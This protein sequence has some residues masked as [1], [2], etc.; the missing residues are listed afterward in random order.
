MLRGLHSEFTIINNKETKSYLILLGS[1]SLSFSLDTE[2]T[3]FESQ[4]SRSQFDF[5]PSDRFY[6]HDSLSQGVHS[7]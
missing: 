3:V 6:T 4:I 1:V 7:K 5:T 2:K